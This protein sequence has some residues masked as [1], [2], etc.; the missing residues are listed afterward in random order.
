M[1]YARTYMG[2]Y[3]RLRVATISDTLVTE[4]NG[5]SEIN[6]DGI[7]ERTGVA[8]AVRAPRRLSPFSSR[9]TAASTVRFALGTFDLLR[10]VC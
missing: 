3:Q 2:I 1:L 4:H 5:Q 6:I 7:A 8:L 9:R 10:G